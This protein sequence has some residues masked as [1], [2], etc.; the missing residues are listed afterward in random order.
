MRRL[1][2]ISQFHEEY[3][4]VTREVEQSREQ[5]V[6]DH[7]ENWFALIDE[8]TEAAQYFKVLER[9]VFIDFMS[10]ISKVKEAAPSVSG[11]TKGLSWPVGPERRLGM[12]LLTFREIAERRI[13]IGDFADRFL[14]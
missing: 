11:H 14:M 13:V 12:Q 6:A 8:T 4:Q 10:F 7:I 3:D 9:V 5:F 1:K 2:S